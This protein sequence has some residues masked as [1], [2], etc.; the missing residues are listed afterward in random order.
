MASYAASDP[1]FNPAMA[2]SMAMGLQG[3]VAA[4]WHHQGRLALAAMAARCPGRRHDLLRHFSVEMDASF[5]EAAVNVGQAVDDSRPDRPGA[6]QMSVDRL[7]LER[8]AEIIRSLRA[9]VLI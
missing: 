3:T 8:H 5:L 6:P 1:G 2:T 9:A 4:S 7:P